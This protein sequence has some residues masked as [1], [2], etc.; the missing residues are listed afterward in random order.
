MA[1]GNIINNTSGVTT[2]T[3]LTF[4]P[5]TN[6]IVGTSTNNNASA[7]YVG[8][9]ISSVI[10]FASSVAVI[11]NTST[12]ITSISL[13]AGD[14]EVYGNVNQTTVPTNNTQLLG[15]SSTTSA[16]LPDSSLYNNISLASALLTTS[17]GISIPT[18]RYSLSGTTTVYLTAYQVGTAGSGT[19]CGAIYARR[20]R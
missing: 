8:E 9:F 13:T 3:S 5:T 2:V 7:G 17:T 11:V 1:T 18:R 16:T 14:W 20:I 6:G 15:W 12:D 10:P 4:N 19:V